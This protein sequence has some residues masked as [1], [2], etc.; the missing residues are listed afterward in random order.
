MTSLTYK[1]ALNELDDR[2]IKSIK[3][4]IP[5][6]ILVEEY[7]LSLR[8]A[9]TVA[10]GRKATEEI[11]KQE[12]DRLLVVVGPCSIHDVRSGL[13]Y[14]K[15]LAEY[16]ESAKDDLHIVMR[17][18]FEKPRTTVGWKGLINDPNLN[19]SFQINKGLRLARGFLLE[20]NNLGLPAGTEFLDTISPQYTADLISWGA[21]GAR[22]TESQV[23]R[24]LSSGLSMPIGFK[25][26]TDGSISIAVDAI[27]AASSE[28]VF[29]SVTKQGIS[30]IVE[31]NGNDACHVILRGANTGPN[32]SPEHVAS[33]SSKLTSSGLPA[34]IM[35]D[36]SHGNSE[37]KHANQMRV[38]ESI[39]TQLSSGDENSCNIFGVMIES[40]LV[41]GQQKIPAEGPTGLTYGQSITD[42]CVNWDTTV[43]ALDRL[44]EGVRKRRESPEAKRWF[45][46]RLS[47]C[48]SSEGVNDHFLRAGREGQTGF[49]D[50]ALATLGR[51]Q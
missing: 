30:A 11:V 3:P 31:T 49:N 34:R 21:I 25:N 8:A 20:V 50:D 9:Q 40:N 35:I 1:D 46:A 17:V 48:S 45:K 24:E 42:A 37:K 32:Y 2:R 29:L 16:S 43:Q 12:D 36:C 15:K 6:Q 22:T 13:E 7:P 10:Y 38:V 33:V 18:Y 41:E 19:G 39:A 28:H 23:H 51:K 26:G 47:R 5:P 14:A 27:K 44:R 4:L